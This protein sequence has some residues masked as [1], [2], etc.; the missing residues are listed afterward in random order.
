[1][2]PRSHTLAPGQR[3]SGRKGLSLL[4]DLRLRVKVGVTGWRRRKFQKGFS[5]PK[6]FQARTGSGPH[7]GPAWS[8]NPCWVLSLVR[9]CP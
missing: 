7:P 1:M 8:T 3:E 4:G 6:G 2:G 9:Y 5:M